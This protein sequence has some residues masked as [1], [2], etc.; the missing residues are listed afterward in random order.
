MFLGQLEGRVS[1]NSLSL[2]NGKGFKWAVKP[3][4]GLGTSPELTDPSVGFLKPVFSS[5]ST[6]EVGEGSLAGE[7][8][9]AQAPLMAVPGS[10]VT[11]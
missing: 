5:P 7:G 8:G 6:F 3:Y 4:L 1:L 9:S 2:L 10:G 11:A